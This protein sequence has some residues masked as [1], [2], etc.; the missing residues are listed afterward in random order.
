MEKIKF[1]H[2]FKQ[3]QVLDRLKKHNCASLKFH[4][5]V[6]KLG[7]LVEGLHL[8]SIM[9][10]MINAALWAKEKQTPNISNCQILGYIL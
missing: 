10:I 1:P 3:V 4:L 9:K 8:R 6:V 2:I 5:Y 7:I